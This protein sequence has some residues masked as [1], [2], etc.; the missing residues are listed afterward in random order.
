VTLII[1]AAVCLTA[2]VI[3]EWFQKDPIVDVR[4]FKNANFATA[5]TMMFMVGAISFAS[6]VLMPQ[7]LQTLMGYTAQTAGMVMSA[8]AMV[9]LVELP[10]VGRLTTKVQARYMIA[11][12][13]LALM[14]TMYLSTKRID[15]DISFA[16]ATG[17]RILQY[18][19]LGFIFIPASTAA[20][21][22]VAAEKNNAV[23]GLVNFMRNI[24]SSVGTSV[25]TTVLARR[26]QFHQGRLVERITTGDSNF[27]NAINGTAQQ[28]MR[29][30]L[31]MADAHKQ[32]LARFYAM[33]RAQAATLS[34]IDT[35]WVLSVSAG[36]MFL[37]AFTLKKSDLHGGSKLHLE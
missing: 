11:S 13:W 16:S 30:G 4:L 22:G 19:P 21:A 34:Y 17:L 7:F 5:S 36:V 29:A 27:Q 35:Y 1:L 24:G 9:L 14:C 6:T 12:G 10:F 37:L 32:A 3:Y 25:V 15:L 20:Y 8:A 31:S 28:L 33:V 26:S 18:A 23:A 2:L